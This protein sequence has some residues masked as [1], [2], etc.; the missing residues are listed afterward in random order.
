MFGGGALSTGP[1]ITL[2][3][4]DSTI[5]RNVAG[6]GVALEAV[7]SGPVFFERVTVDSNNALVQFG[8]GEIN[9]S[10]VLGAGVFV[11]GGNFT[12]DRSVFRNNMNMGVRAAFRSDPQL[13]HPFRRDLP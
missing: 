5:T 2:R 8:P 7:N 3:V 6:Q 9:T 13:R 4:T 12:A 11:S 10:P 1:G